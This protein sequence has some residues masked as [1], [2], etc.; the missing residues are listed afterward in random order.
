MK[1]KLDITEFRDRL[2]NNTKIGLPHL[3][4]TLGLF[5]IF[6][7]SSKIFME[8]LMIQLFNLQ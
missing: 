2:K 6:F 1:S 5:S 8:N 7:Y 4:I 3:Q